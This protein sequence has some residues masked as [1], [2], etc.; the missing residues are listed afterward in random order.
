MT[1][2]KFTGDGVTVSV[3]GT[4]LSVYEA[5]LSEEWHV[6]DSFWLSSTVKWSFCRTGTKQQ[7]NITLAHLF[8]NNYRRKRVSIT[9]KKKL[10]SF[11]T[12]AA[13]QTKRLRFTTEL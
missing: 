13:T 3:A 7:K 8:N 2:S 6:A 5:S 10:F 1:S 9:D 11:N 12:F 4:P